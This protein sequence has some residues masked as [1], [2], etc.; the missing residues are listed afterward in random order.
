MAA[1][2]RNPEHFVVCGGSSLLALGLVRR[3]TTRDVDILARLETGHLVRA[4][5]LA[6]EVV[7]DAEAVR[8]ELN[9]PADWLNTGPSDDTFF[10]HGFPEGLASRVTTRRYGP[11]LQI[12][13]IGRYDQIHF[14]LY[15]AADQGG[16]RHLQ[17]LLELAP[18][19]EELLA[20]AR[21]TR[22]QDASDG[23]RHVLGEL[24]T[25]LV[26]G[27]LAGQL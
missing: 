24:L 4:K 18:T 17:D 8:G 10:Q 23:F 7:E 26:H 5:P 14:K 6:A 3:A 9:L 19:A 16:G 20:A 25:H 11:A 15:A 13:F 21:W 12:S 1:R 27:N 2:G 22:T